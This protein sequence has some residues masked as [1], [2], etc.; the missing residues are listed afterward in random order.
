MFYAPSRIRPDFRQ[1]VRKPAREGSREKRAGESSGQGSLHSLPYVP[2]GNGSFLILTS[3]QRQPDRI[4]LSGPAGHNTA[5][6]GNSRS[7]EASHCFPIFPRRAHRRRGCGS[8]TPSGTMPQAAPDAPG[9]RG[10]RGLFS[11]IRPPGDERILSL[12]VSAPPACGKFRAVPG[13]CPVLAGSPFSA[14]LMKILP[15][16]PEACLRLPGMPDCKFPVS[17]GQRQGF[18]YLTR[19]C[20]AHKKASFPDTGKRLRWSFMDEWLHMLHA[21]RFLGA[22]RVVETVQGADKVTRNTAD[23][24]ELHSFAN[25]PGR[26]L[27]SGLQT[28]FHKHGN[29]LLINCCGCQAGEEPLRQPEKTHRAHPI[30]QSPKVKEEPFGS[31][32]V[33]KILLN[34]NTGRRFRPEEAFSAPGRLRQASGGI[35]KNFFHFF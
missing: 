32:L 18:H 4:F 22:L 29:C 2:Y 24:L 9:Y 23:A 11:G 15:V 33:K 14:G 26:A 1:A 7:A 21:I 6:S 13:F 20:R 19:T 35:L 17:K 5:G 30:R 31:S 16:R 28:G 3:P 27:F 10:M 25:H 8:G 34:K 12:R